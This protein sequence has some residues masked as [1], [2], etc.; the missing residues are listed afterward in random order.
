MYDPILLEDLTKWLNEE[1]L[2][3]VGYDGEV[4]P[5]Q[6]KSWC[7]RKGICCLFKESRRNKGVGG[8]KKIGRE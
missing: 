5:L 8:V 2:E 7:M 1:G 6:V 4:M 3:R